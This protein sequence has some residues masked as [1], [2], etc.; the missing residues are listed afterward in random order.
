MRT[1]AR[2]LV[3]PTRTI[4]LLEQKETIR[5]ISSLRKEACSASVHHLARVPTQNCLADCP[6]KSSEKANNLIS[7]VKTGKLCEVD[8]HP[9]FRTLM[10]HKALST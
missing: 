3:T 6:T 5:M 8:I 2:N 4:H 9:N 1:D 10:A 7:A